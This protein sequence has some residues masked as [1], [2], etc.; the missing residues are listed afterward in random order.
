[1]Q[2]AN[3]NDII[4]Q[5]GLEPLGR[6][7]GLFASTYVSTQL[8]SDGQCAGTGIF[9]LLRGEAFS[10]LHCLTGDE[11]YHF[12]LGDP[13]EMLNLDPDGSGRII[14]LGS[15]ILAGQKVQHL[16]P[17]GTWQGSRLAPGGSWALLGT[18]MCP[19]YSDDG[20]AHGDTD[21]LVRR[22][23][24]FADAIRRLTGRPLH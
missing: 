4:E 14:T 23:P 21:E 1:M 22:Y 3:V 20:Y 13:V 24:D 2:S 9:Y 8:T 17:A 19:G 12:Y 15:D 6:E 10:H 7:G 11:L 16:V 5:L 18:T